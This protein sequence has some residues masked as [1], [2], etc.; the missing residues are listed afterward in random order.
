MKVG[1]LV[2]LSA[3]ANRGKRYKEYR[4]KC[5]VVLRVEHYEDGRIKYLVVDWNV[6]D[7]KVRNELHLREDLKVAKIAKG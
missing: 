1:T 2:M 3:N 5:G 6:Q 7:P 4:G